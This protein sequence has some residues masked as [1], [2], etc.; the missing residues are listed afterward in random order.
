[1]WFSGH[2]PI[3]NPLF[4]LSSSNSFSTSCS[5]FCSS[6]I[7]RN[8]GRPCLCVYEGRGRIKQDFDSFVVSSGSNT[9]IKVCREDVHV[10]FHVSLCVSKVCIY[11]ICSCVQREI[12]AIWHLAAAAETRCICGLWNSKFVFQSC[13]ML[14]YLSDEWSMRRDPMIEQ[15]KFASN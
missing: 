14:D 3:F 6:V 2:P 15:R 7:H 4:E 5:F 13:Y 10:C 9:I 8:P 12:P 1:M 11:S